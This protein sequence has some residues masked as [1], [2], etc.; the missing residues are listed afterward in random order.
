MAGQVRGIP[1]QRTVPGAPEAK[2]VSICP[3]HYRGAARTE[4]ETI[5]WAFVRKS[6]R[7]PL[8]RRGPQE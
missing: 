2:P 1:E 8:D 5:H 6:N 4:A 3:R 7:F